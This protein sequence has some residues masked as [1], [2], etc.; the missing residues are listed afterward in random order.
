MN[1]RELA[2]LIA[3]YQKAVTTHNID[4]IE[5]IVQLLPEKIHAIDR[6]H[7]N[8]QKLLMQLKSVHRLAM[9]TIKKDIAVLHSQLHDAEHNKVRDL[10]YK[11]TQLNQ[12]L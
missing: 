11:K 5:R 3:I 9:A 10:A 7:P 1:E 2:R 4:A 6:S 8:H 12:T